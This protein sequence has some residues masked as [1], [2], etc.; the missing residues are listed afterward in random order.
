MRFYN[1]RNNLRVEASKVQLF[2]SCPYEFWILMPAK[3]ITAAEAQ[4]IAELKKKRQFKI[5]YYRGLTIEQMVALK[6]EQMVQLLTCRKRR[7]F[8]RKLGTKQKSLVKRLRKAK[9]NAEVGEKPATI[10]THLRNMV[11]IPEMAGSIIG[12]H[13]GQVRLIYSSGCSTICWRVDG[14]TERPMARF[15]PHVLQLM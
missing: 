15:A 6:N 5:H 13:N 14:I 8:R 9:K 10:K 11:I 7:V 2:K 4:R 12:V 3:K 1:D